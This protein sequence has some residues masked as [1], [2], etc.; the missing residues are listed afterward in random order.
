M[1][2]NITKKDLLI[3]F[4]AVGSLWI[5]GIIDLVVYWNTLS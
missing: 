4:G 5:Y 3:G 2:G 1:M